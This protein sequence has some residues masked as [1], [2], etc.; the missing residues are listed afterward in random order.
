MARLANRNADAVPPPPERGG[1]VGLTATQATVTVALCSLLSAVL[2]AWITGAWNRQT[3][4]GV[5]QTRFEGNIEIER[6]KLQRD[7]I[8]QAIETADSEEAKARLGFFARTGLI[9]DFASG[10]IEFLADDTAKVPSLAVDGRPAFPA[11]VAAIEALELSELEQNVLGRVGIV[12]KK[13]DADEFH[14]NATLVAKDLVA[15]PGHCGSG[16]VEDP[17]VF[18]RRPDPP[19]LLDGER[20]EAAYDMTPVASVGGGRGADGVNL[21]RLA[22]EDPVD[23]TPARLRDPVKDEIVSLVGWAPDQYRIQATA[24]VA[25]RGLTLAPLHS[26]AVLH[27]DCRVIGVENGVVRTDCVS[28]NGMSGAAIFAVSDGALVTMV[29]YGDEEIGPTDG[30]TLGALAEVIETELR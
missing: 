21:F 12:M 11:S 23:V 27:R 28:S 14:C 30:P 25:Q 22:G 3:S 13:H 8:L 2:T 20:E 17:L 7:L 5:E 26:G 4:V 9:P 15:V 24:P 6:F 29:A 18:Q 19:F 16:A 10:V 1:P